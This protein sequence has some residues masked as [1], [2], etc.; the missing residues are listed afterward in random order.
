MKFE[1]RLR[2]A[3]AFVAVGA[4]VVAAGLVPAA[5][6][7]DA[8]LAPA[9]GQKVG[10][11][12]Q[13]AQP[14]R[15]VAPPAVAEASKPK[16]QRPDA[17]DLEKIRA[18][19]PEAAPAVPKRPRKVLVFTRAAGFVHSSI[20][21]GAK[22]FELMGE[23]TGAFAA[24][25]TDDVEAFAPENLRSFDAVVMM[26]T[27]GS[28]FVPK[29]AKEDLLYD[30]KGKELPADLRRAKELRESLLSFVRSGKGLM[31][32]H[33][34]T[35][36]SYGWK[37]YGLMIGG[38]FN[39][40]P[41]GK[42]TLAIDD[43]MNPVNAPFVAAVAATSK[44]F[45][46]GDEIYRFREPYSRD[47]LRVLTSID[48]EASKLSQGLEARSDHDYGVSWLNKFGEGRV[49]YCSLG[50]AE[51]T[52]WNPTVLKHY[53]AGLQFALGDL[54][55]DASPSGPFPAGRTEAGKRL[56]AMA[57]Q[58]VSGDEKWY[59]DQK[60]PKEEALTGTLTAVPAADGPSVLQ[61]TYWYKLDD[62]A[63]FTGGKKDR[64]LEGLV[65]KRVEAKGKVVKLELEGRDVTEVWVAQVRPAKG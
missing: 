44:P 13:P 9:A 45:E 5:Q 2:A 10:P 8:P 48:V 29:G 3:A 49:F 50:H 53:L 32:V 26:S 37:E 62:R 33:A 18:A 57:W 60:E 6:S 43:P 41:W 65:G 64:V 39:S 40:H 59:R 21:V 38:Y 58:R 61:R 7:A 20:P 51:A 47:R 4:V 15:P 34:A 12:A 54:E 1:R 28:L 16:P 31:G 14:A 42:V 22:A 35:D 17:K 23:K 19:L 11:T 25:A 27:T 30:P 63:V 55:A 52:Y 56:A 24:V 46:I 36:S